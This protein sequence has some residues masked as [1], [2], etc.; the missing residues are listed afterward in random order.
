MCKK[1]TMQICISHL[2]SFEQNSTSAGK[3]LPATAGDMSWEDPLE[4]ETATH[5]S[6]LAEKSYGQR[7]LLGYSPKSHKELDMTEHSTTIHIFNLVSFSL[8]III[9]NTTDFTINLSTTTVDCVSY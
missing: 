3:D 6:I 5:S 9:T 4:E 7:S 2:S 8:F 1:D